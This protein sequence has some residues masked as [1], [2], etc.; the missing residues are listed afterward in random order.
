MLVE[1]APT[2]V[3]V[4][5]LSV[6]TAEFELVNVT[7]PPDDA[8]ADSANG[9]SPRDFGG[10]AEKEIVWLALFTTNDAALDVTLV[11]EFVTTTVYEPA[12]PATAELIT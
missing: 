7:T 1:P 2:R 8:E 12:S 5:P 10:K 9:G 11:T 3:T 6:A 4:L